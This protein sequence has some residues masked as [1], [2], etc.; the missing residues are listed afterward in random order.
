MVF[1]VTSTWH[2]TVE[3]YVSEDQYASY[4]SDGSEDS[5][6]DMIEPLE[7]SSKE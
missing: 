5:Y 4:S 2:A 6:F 1:S 7:V 3:M